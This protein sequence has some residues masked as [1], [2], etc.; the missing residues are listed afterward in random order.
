MAE[1]RGKTGKLEHW[2]YETH[3]V[4]EIEGKNG[5]WYRVTERNF[6]SYNGKRRI[7]YPDQTELGNPFQDLTTEDYYG[8]FYYYEENTTYDPEKHKKHS[9][10]YRSGDDRVSTERTSVAGI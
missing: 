10:I 6:R 9:I 5:T 8:P 7:T 1:K 3:W 4:L 2:G